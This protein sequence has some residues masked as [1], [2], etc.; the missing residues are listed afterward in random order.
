MRIYKVPTSGAIYSSNV[1]LLLGDFSRIEDKN[2]LIDAGGDIN[3]FQEIT[4]FPTGVGKKGVD[5]I[6]L[7]HNHFDH[8][9]GISG[10]K[11]RYGSKVYAFSQGGLVDTLLKPNQKIEVADTIATIIYTPGH[12]NDSICI[13][14]EKEKILFSGDTPIAVYDSEGS[15]SFEYFDALKRLSYLNLDII[16]PGHGNPINNPQEV[17]QRSIKNVEKSNIF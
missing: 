9:Q 4:N 7:T 17:L 6:I 1:Y 11:N 8:T 12:S 2:T 5:Q 10:L 16:Y 13:Y 15:H 3:I 14:F